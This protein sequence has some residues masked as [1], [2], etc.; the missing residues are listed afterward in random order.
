MPTGKIA[1]QGRTIAWNALTQVHAKPHV[2]FEVENNA[3]F[4]FAGSH[5]G[6]MQNFVTPAAFYVV[7][8]G[9]GSRRI[10]FSS[11]T[12]ACRSQRRAFTP[13]TTT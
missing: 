2:W 5:D 12:R 11:L 4:Y 8:A 1:T 13:I 10:R 6:K 9:N 3:T 7:G